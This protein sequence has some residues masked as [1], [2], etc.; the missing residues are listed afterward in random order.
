MQNRNE[1]L[2]AIVRTTSDYRH[3]ELSAPTAC[4][5]DRWIR[6]F[7]PGLQLPLL[8]ELGHVLNT[9]YLGLNAVTDFCGKLVES[10]S[11]A[12]SDPAKFWKGAEFLAIQKNGDS[13]KDMLKLF[14]GI[15]KSSFG[16]ECNRSASTNG[17]VVYLDD[18]IFSGNR[19]AIDLCDWIQNHASPG[20]TIHII[21]IACHTLGEYHLCERLKEQIL[22]SKSKVSFKVW[23]LASVENRL[24]YRKDAEVLW[25][26]ELPNDQLTQDYQKISH[27]YPFESRPKGG[28]LGPFSS[29]ANR[30]LL[31]QELLL[32]GLKIRSFCKDP[33][34]VMRPLGFGHFGL[35]F[36]SMI[37]THRNCPNN[38]PLAL[39]WGNPHEDKDHPLSKW[40]PLFPR[41]TYET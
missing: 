21:V 26:S 12:G 41:K 34:D 19:A 28:R 11:I 35:G 7:D 36:G 22:S 10:K 33:K 23:R 1:L 4:H 6:Q 27:K 31:E 30:Q 18:V 29:E 14:D 5:V 20:Q 39:W 24:K 17:A 3:G 37:V 32:A 25:P 40:Y 15:L 38:C 9:T 13:Q 16:Y 8:A 2:E